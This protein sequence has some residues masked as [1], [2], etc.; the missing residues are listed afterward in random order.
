MTHDNRVNLT[1]AEFRS[2]MRVLFAAEGD[3]AATLLQYFALTCI[4]R[5]D[6]VERARKE[7][8]DVAG[9][10]RFP[11]LHDLRTSKVS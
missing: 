9:R 5:P 11:N 1:P 2:L 3:S 6:A 7:Q 10:S 8:D 4:L